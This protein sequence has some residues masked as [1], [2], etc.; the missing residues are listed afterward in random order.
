MFYLSKTPTFEIWLRLQWL[1]V[2]GCVAAAG[3]S[4]PQPATAS[5]SQNFK[6]WCFTQVKHSLLWPASENGVEVAACGCV[7]ASVAVDLAVFL[8]LSLSVWGCSPSYLL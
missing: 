8:R 2:A 3:Q 4:R 7:R 1:A 5:R 6:S